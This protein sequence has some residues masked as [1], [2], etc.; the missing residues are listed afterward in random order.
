MVYVVTKAAIMDWL[1]T[2]V[3]LDYNSE[4]VDQFKFHCIMLSEHVWNLFCVK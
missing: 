2:F 1:I 3:I 4:A